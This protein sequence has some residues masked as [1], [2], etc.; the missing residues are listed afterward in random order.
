MYIGLMSPNIIQS[1]ATTKNYHGIEVSWPAAYMMILSSHVSIT[2]IMFKLIYIDNFFGFTLCNY[3]C[4]LLQHALLAKPI[5][6][7]PKPNMVEVVLG[8]II[9]PKDDI[10]VTTI[11]S[12]Y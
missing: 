7:E 5:V 4:C 1:M 9:F 11:H 3:I 6:V 2:T 12:Y 8:L 10:F